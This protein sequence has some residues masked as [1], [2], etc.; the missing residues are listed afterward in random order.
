M[1]KNF[2]GFNVVTG[3]PLQF[4]DL[5]SSTQGKIGRQIVE[6]VQFILC[7]GTDEA[8]V[9]RECNQ[10]GDFKPGAPSDVGEFRKKLAKW[11]GFASI[12]SI[13]GGEGQQFLVHNFII[14]LR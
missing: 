10:I 6:Q 3:G 8:G 1:E 11:C 4:F 5:S 13:E 12:T 14:S 9:L 7:K 2:D